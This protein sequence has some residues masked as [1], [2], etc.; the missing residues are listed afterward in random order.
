MAMA[1]E[2][3]NTSADTTSTP[4]DG[5]SSFLTPQRIKILGGGLGLILL[6]AAG[7][8]FSAT[9]KRNKE[10]FAASALD[11]AR[12]AAAQNN[13]GV[14]VEGFTRVAKTYAGSPSAYEATLGIA[15]ARLVS[16]QNE[17]AIATL[18]DFL[19][20]NPPAQYASP[21]NGLMGTAY[22]NTGKFAEAEAAYKKAADLAELDYLKATNLLDAARAANLAKKPAEAK[23]IY[24]TIITKYPKTGSKTEAQVRLSEMEASKAS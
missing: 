6:V 18:T 13:M 20:T 10:T 24:N 9:A 22:E 7:I 3:S 21:A 8:W 1:A 15:Q 2:A 4:V 5:M 14:A 23:E 17:L 16:D 11:E 19:K 12:Q